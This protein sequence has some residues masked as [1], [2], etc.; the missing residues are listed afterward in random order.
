MSDPAENLQPDSDAVLG[1][2]GN[3]LKEGSEKSA[4]TG[5]NLPS[6]P[7]QS[8][9][10]DRGVSP[11]KEAPSIRPVPR[12]SIQVFC[13]SATTGEVFQK[14]AEDRRLSKAH[15]TVQMGGIAGAVEHFEDTPTP[16]LIVVECLDDSETLFRHLAQLAHVCDPTTKVVVI[17]QMND[18]SMYRELIR[19]GISEYLV[20][21]LTP[22]QII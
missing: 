7:G 6:V 22:L 10:V 21:P 11:V 18:I 5:A 20:T 4:K 19:Q 2:D 9:G 13:D 17:G 15:M 12:I 1:P 3:P 14:A 8:F 16:N